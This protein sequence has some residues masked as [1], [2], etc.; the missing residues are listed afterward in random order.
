MAKI[1]AS[2]IAGTSVQTHREG[3][4]I[5]KARYG[6]CSAFYTHGKEWFFFPIP[7][8]VIVDDQRANLVKV[9]VLYKTIGTA[10]IVKIELCDGR[11]VLSEIPANLSGKHDEGIDAGNSWII[12]P[13]IPMKYGLN[14]GVLVDFGPP[15]KVLVPGIEFVTAGANF[16]T[17]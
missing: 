3:Y 2:W 8:P 1:Q 14:L 7:T 6:S 11:K 13:S 9:Y 4:F 15:T 12:Q 16:E 17:P 10:R 5:S